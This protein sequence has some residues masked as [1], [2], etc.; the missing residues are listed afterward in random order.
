M[1][2]FIY[3]TKVNIAII[4]MYGFYGLVFRNDTFFQWKRILLLSMQVIA[5]LYPLINVSLLLND[6]IP[7]MSAGKIFPSYYLNEIIITINQG[8]PGGSSSLT[9]YLPALLTGMY[10]L[11]AL[12]LLIRMA[13]QII[14]IF[15]LLIRTQKTYINGQTV[16][17]KEGI[18]TPFSFFRYIVLD[19]QHYPADE[20]QEIIRHETTH[21]NQY[22][23]LDMVLIEIMTAF[24]WF[25]PFVWLMKREIRMNLEYLADRSVIDSGLGKEH[26]QFH[27]LRLTYHKAAATITN[28][29]N[30]S[31]LKKRI[32]MM[33]KK[34]TPRLGLAKYLF[35]LPLIAALLIFNNCDKN[36]KNTTAS[37]EKAVTAIAEKVSETPEVVP[38]SAAEEVFTH[39][40]E[41]PRYPGGDDALM[42]YL[43]DNI[44]YPV[45]ASDSGVQGRVVI[46]FIVRSDGSVDDAQ[47]VKSLNP[48]CDKEALRAVEEMPKW[49]PGRQKGAPVDVYYT[50]PVVYRLSKK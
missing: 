9:D 38:A 15:F 27:L 18:Q 30:V 36:T 32:F 20:L 33:N 22:H 41:M 34:E 48:E 11:V 24:C 40:E 14:S 13:V 25:N 28:N 10:F 5:L 49:T 47:V 6:E 19:P 2:F 12:A 45:S 4:V 35:V 44:V 8:R 37:E 23:S 3:L 1:E 31:P 39:V 46:R 43:S 29:F 7:V 21:I 42:K 16:Y 17:R 26:Y 50:L